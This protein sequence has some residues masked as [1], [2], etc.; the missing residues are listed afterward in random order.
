MI[1][2]LTVFLLFFSLKDQTI[3]KEPKKNKKRNNIQDTSKKKLTFQNE[4]FIRAILNLNDFKELPSELQMTKDWKRGKSGEV[5]NI[6]W[7]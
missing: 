6:K 4:A 2:N 5:Q 1:K 7:F 3:S